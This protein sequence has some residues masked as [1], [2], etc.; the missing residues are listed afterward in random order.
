[1]MRSTPSRSGSGNIT[2]AS[3]TTVV[4]PEVSASMFM[5]NSP[6]PP[7]ATTS[8]IG[9]RPYAPRP[10]TLLAELQ[11]DRLGAASRGSVRLLGAPETKWGG[12]NDLRGNYSTAQRLS[13]VEVGK[14]RE[15]GDRQRFGPAAAVQAQ[16]G[17]GSRNRVRLPTPVRLQRVGERLAP[18]RKHRLDERGEPCGIGDGRI[19]SVE[20]QA[21]QRR[22]DLGRRAKCTG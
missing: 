5:P 7:S 4:S 3:T 6:S 12:M 10:E 1:M 20:R 18:S 22:E 9:K 13:S 2:P 15:F 8:S 21:D 14:P 16:L 11:S 17:E 19:R